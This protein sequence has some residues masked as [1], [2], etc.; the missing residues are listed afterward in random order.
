METNKHTAPQGAEQ[1]AERVP[2][3]VLNALLPINEQPTDRDDDETARPNIEV[4]ATLS[5]ET[6]DFIRI[7]KTLW[8]M[9][10]VYSRALNGTYYG[11]AQA[12]ER[13]KTVLGIFQQL[14]DEIA[15]DMGVCIADRISE[16][17]DS[18]L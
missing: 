10:P 17:K 6:E 2:L 7:I 11:G 5:N 15:H 14:R 13:Y 1:V 18:Y 8:D 4:L 16:W 3:S 12:N 9:L